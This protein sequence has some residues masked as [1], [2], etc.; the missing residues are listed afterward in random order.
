MAIISDRETGK[1]PLSIGTSL[2]FEGIF[3]IHETAVI[4]QPYPIFTVDEMWIN[5]KTLIRNI[6][7][8]LKKDT[9]KRLQYRDYQETLYAEM[10]CIVDEVHRISN[11][12]VWVRFYYPTHRSLLTRYPGATLKAETASRALTLKQI[13]QWVMDGTMVQPPFVI[14]QTNLDITANNP[15]ILILTHQ[16]IDLLNIH[17]VHYVG[18]M[19]SHT[20]LVK[21]RHH[22]YTKLKGGS[23]EPRIPFNAITIQIFG[24]SGDE[25]QSAP[26][27]LRHELIR[28]ADQLKWT[29]NLTVSQMLRGIHIAGNPELKDLVKMLG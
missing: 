6:Y 25:L 14:E 10:S 27:R 1:L 8:S 20:G 2:A 7:G 5:V 26:I 13:E 16:P 24:D 29:Q 9:I 28:V 19:E 22:W 15:R 3:G 12:K 17:N 11:G 18:L 23:K 21:D 4:Q